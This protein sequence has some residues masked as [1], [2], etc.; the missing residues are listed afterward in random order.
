MAGNGHYLTLYSRIKGASVLKFESGGRRES[1]RADPP[2]PHHGWGWGENFLKICYHQ[3]PGNGT[4]I[5]KNAFGVHL[6]IFQASSWIM[7]LSCGRKMEGTSPLQKCGGKCPLSPP[8]PWSA[9]M[10]RIVI[11]ASHS[12]YDIVWATEMRDIS[13]SSNKEMCDF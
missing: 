7:K 11:D 3:M 1:K 2:Q 10:C 12:S 4:L 6:N 8:P 9:P 5:L 13:Y